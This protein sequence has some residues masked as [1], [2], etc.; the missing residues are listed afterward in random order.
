MS[1]FSFFCGKHK[2]NVFS[3]FD[4]TII[5]S[6]FYSHSWVIALAIFLSVYC[7]SSSGRQFLKAK[8]VIANSSCCI[9]A[10]CFSAPHFW[11]PVFSISKAIKGRGNT[12]RDADGRDGQR[13]ESWAR[14][15]SSQAPRTS[16]GC[17]MP[18]T[19]LYSCFICPVVASSSG[20]PFSLKSA[21]KIELFSVESD[22]W[23]GKMKKMKI[24]P[25]AAQMS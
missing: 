18:R 15:T 24:Q 16:W 25:P 12:R 11:L 22:N 20:E 4:A 21:W 1:T 10:Y 19:R 6:R 2:Q 13:S 23:H 14:F 8:P 17:L 5:F 7:P 3:L 9:S